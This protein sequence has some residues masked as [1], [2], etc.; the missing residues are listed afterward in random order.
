MHPRSESVKTLDLRKPHEWYE[1]ARS[2]RRRLVYHMGPTN[3]G[4]TYQALAAM[5]A[6]KSGMY[7]G[8]LRLLAMEVYDE[9]NA[10]G[11][12]CNL[13][14]GALAPASTCNLITGVGTCVYMYLH[15]WCADAGSTF[16]NL[17]T[18]ALGAR[19]PL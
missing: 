15:H 11:T 18:D 9:L 12:F 14:T 2:L 7:C 6:A 17:T 5:R 1:F 10:G 19:L 8:P 16:C 13:T 4:K 3:S